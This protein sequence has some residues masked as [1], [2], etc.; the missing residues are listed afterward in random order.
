MTQ[1]APAAAGLQDCRNAW[2]QTLEHLAEADPRIV[3][4]V[5]GRLVGLRAPGLGEDSLVDELVE[6]TGLGIGIV[7]DAILHGVTELEDDFVL[8]ESFADA[9]VPEGESGESLP[10]PAGS[11]AHQV[12]L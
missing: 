3:A 8:D 4:V 9:D 12:H 7:R 11:M 10:A 2:V 5:N 6:R 1:A